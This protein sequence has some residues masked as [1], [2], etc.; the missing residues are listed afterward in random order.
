[1]LAQPGDARI[2]FVDAD[3]TWIRQD[4]MIF[5]SLSGFSLDHIPLESVYFQADLPSN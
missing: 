3:G 4:G 2:T 1:M 5:S